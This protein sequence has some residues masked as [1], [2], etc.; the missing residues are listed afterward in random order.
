MEVDKASLH[1]AFQ[2]KADICVRLEEKTNRMAASKEAVKQQKRGYSQLK[3]EL[4][5]AL[6]EVE[7]ERAKLIVSMYV[8]VA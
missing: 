2:E 8:T 3:T 7:V 1:K 6:Q 5:K 4:H